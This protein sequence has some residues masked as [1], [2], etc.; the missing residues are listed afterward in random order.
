MADSKARRF[1]Q[2]VMPHLDSAY[3]LARYLTRNDADAQDVVQ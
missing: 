1:E 3:N 2:L